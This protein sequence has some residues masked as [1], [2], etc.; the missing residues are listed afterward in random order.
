MVL[1]PDESP[2]YRRYAVINGNDHRADGRRIADAGCGPG[3][4]RQTHAASG[5]TLNHHFNRRTET[6]RSP[7]TITKP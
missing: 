2:A 1:I 5:Q 3:N 6:A 4:R 7:A